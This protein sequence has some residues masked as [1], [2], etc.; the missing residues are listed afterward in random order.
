MLR[1]LVR[2]LTT[3]G[4]RTAVRT[5]HNELR[6]NN[7][8]LRSRV[9]ARRLRRSRGLQLHLGSGPNRKVG[10]L[11]VD[12]SPQADLRVDLREPFPLPDGCARII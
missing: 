6:V 4:L 8:H 2:R 1:R 5:L 12:V 3:K 9:T 10:W 11:N 7:V